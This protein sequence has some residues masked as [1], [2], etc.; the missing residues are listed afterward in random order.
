MNMSPQKS[1]ASSPQLTCRVV[2]FWSLACRDN[3]QP[4]HLRTCEA[5]RAY[6]LASHQL[7]T[8]LREN[9]F[10]VQVEMPSNLEHRVMRAVHS[11]APL[12]PASR[13]P[14]RVF[15]YALAGSAAALAVVTIAYFYS[16]AHS[17]PSPAS[18]YAADVAQV[19][20]SV[21]AFPANLTQKIQAPAQ[22]LNENPLQREV[23]NVYS[24]AESA[25][26]FLAVNF[27]PGSSAQSE[28]QLAVPDPQR[29]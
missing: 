16:G 28:T 19:V 5:C 23:Q 21:R 11:Y 7:D 2:R 29:S 6:F 25:L 15:S 22:R 8:V 18:E 14:S 4:D 17:H 13:Q 27:L 24:D 9:S 10:S 1:T 3:A 12:T 26:N 20:A